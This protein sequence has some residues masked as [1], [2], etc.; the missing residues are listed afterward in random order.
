[1]INLGVRWKN[2]LQISGNSYWVSND[3]IKWERGY[4]TKS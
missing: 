1:M 4:M 3:T 2:D